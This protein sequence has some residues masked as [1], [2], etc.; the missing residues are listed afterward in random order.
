MPIY[1]SLDGIQGD[2]TAQGYEGQ[3]ELQ[4]LSN[5]VS[6]PVTVGL[7]GGMEASKPSV[8]EIAVTKPTDRA[9]VHLIRA[10]LTASTFASGRI[11]FVKTDRDMLVAYLAIDLTNARISSVAMSSGGD[12]P[13]EQVALVGEQITWTYEPGGKGETAVGFDLVNAKLLPT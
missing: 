13:M 4:A 12:R 9:S 6:V 11:T 5:G 10:A 3:I 8:A 7:G 1:L 2:V